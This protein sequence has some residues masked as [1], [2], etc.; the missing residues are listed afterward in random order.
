[1]RLDVRPESTLLTARLGPLPIA[2]ALDR[3]ADLTRLRA[4]AKLVL[5]AGGEACLLAEIPRAIARD[6]AEACV[7]TAL[8]DAA[9]WLDDPVDPARTPDPAQATKAGLAE[10]AADLA[11]SLVSQPDG[12]LRLDA[13]GGA[14]LQLDV[15]ANGTTRVACQHAV[16]V[17]SPEPAR[18]LTRFALETNGRLRLA[19]LAVAWDGSA[20]ATLTWDALL[21]AGL[22]LGRTL[23]HAAQAVSSAWAATHRPLRLLASEPLASEFLRLRSTPADPVSASLE[24][25][26]P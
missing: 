3:I 20:V 17:V 23:S 13:P 25:N 22:P 4:P 10:A 15:D 7:R 19:R 21:P 16:E 2:R 11:G 5:R 1:M 18:A 6:R 26:T 9:R 14:R 12:C 8:D 24:E